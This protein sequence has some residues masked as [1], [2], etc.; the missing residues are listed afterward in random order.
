MVDIQGGDLRLIQGWASVDV[1][2]LQGDS[3]PADVLSKAMLDYMDLG[4]PLLFKHKNRPIGKVLQWEVAKNEESGRNGVHI[5]G[6]LFD[7][8]KSHNL[9]WD[10]SKK[11]QIKG[12]S[13]G[14]DVP[15]PAEN[16]V[17]ENGREI[18]KKV[19][20]N[21]ISLVLNPANQYAILEEWNRVAKGLDAEKMEERP[22]PDL[23]KLSEVYGEDRANKLVELVGEA[24]A[25][26]LIKSK[27]M[28]GDSD[29]SVA[30]METSWNYLSELFKGGLEDV[31][32]PDPIQTTKEVERPSK[33]VEMGDIL[34]LKHDLVKS[35]LEAKQLKLLDHLLKE[36][37]DARTGDV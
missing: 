12:F 2:D 11:D 1:K 7:K 36:I 37:D 4:G 22:T 17:M 13:I 25:L 24:D 30:D 34:Q 20:L 19:E 8:Y 32:D 18:I 27:I 9:I 14:A 33:P 6:K 23:D 35:S 16:I 21:E 15:N 5:V 31:T 3:I 10:A 29:V 26:S 28:F